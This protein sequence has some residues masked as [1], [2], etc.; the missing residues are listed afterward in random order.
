MEVVL[1]ETK[2]DLKKFIELPYHIYKVDPVW[3]PPLRGELAGQFDPVRNPYL[4]HCR[5]QLFL[6]YDS[7]KPVGR[8][9]AFIDDLAVDFWQEP[10]GLFGYFESPSDNQA[11]HLLLEG[12]RKWLVVHGMQKMRG[13]W[14]F[15]SQEWGS[16]VEGFSPAP[17]VMSPYNPPFYNEQ[18]EEFGLSKIKDLL[19]YQID[20]NQNYQ[21]P[22]RILTLTEK[23]RSRYGINT[24]ILNMKTLDQDVEKII[25]LSNES[26]IKNW[27]YSPVT[28]EEVRAMVH[29]LKQIIQPK[30]VIFAENQTGKAVGFAIAIPDINLLL[31]GLN[32]RLLPFGWLKLLRGIPRLKQYRMFA[33]GVI[34]SY[35]GKGIDA[36]LYRALYDSLYST[37]MQMEIN[38]VLEDN[39]P[40]NNA[41]IKLGAKLYRRYR[42]YEKD[43]S[44]SED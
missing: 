15:V 24:R 13:P 31:K 26:L 41:I 23:I 33:L 3:V 1:V 8:I 18:Y 44:T 2:K 17:V 30:G 27:G 10:I 43:I 37:D 42:V 5:H 34:P 19:V 12:A 4:N 28:D 32:G 40:M 29:D 7:D 36:L 16:V 38:Y 35:H 25:A 22:E 20:H 11:S 21:V 9:A 14:S 39:D 6:L